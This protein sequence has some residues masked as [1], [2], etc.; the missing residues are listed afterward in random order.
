[1]V[2][3]SNLVRQTHEQNKMPQVLPPKRDVHIAEGPSL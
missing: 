3:T 2:E 1:M